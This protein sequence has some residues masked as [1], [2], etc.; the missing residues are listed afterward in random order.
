MSENDIIA[1]YVKSRFPNL[2]ATADFG[3]Y[4]MGVGISETMNIIGESLKD[5]DWKTLK[6]RLESV[7]KQKGNKENG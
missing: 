7:N 2:L 4:K 5:I 6:E 1:E 3:L